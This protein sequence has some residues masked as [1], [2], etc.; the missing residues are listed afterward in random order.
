MSTDLEQDSLKY[1]KDFPPG[2]IKIA[3]SKPCKTQRDLSLSYTPGVAFPCLEIAKDKEKVFDYTNRGNSVAI[4]T[5]GTAVLGL[6]NI[7]PE[8]GLPVMEGKAVLFKKFA[9]ID[10]YPLCVNFDHIQGDAQK[11]EAFVNMVKSIEPSFAG[12]NL[13]DIAAPLCF[14]LQE[15]LDRIMDIPVFHDDQFGTAIIVIGGLI[16]ALKTVGKEFSEIKIVINGAGAAGIS[17]AKLL[18]SFGAKKEH[19]FICDSKGLLVSSRED[20]NLQKRAF[21]LGE[22]HGISKSGAIPQL[23]EVLDGADVFIGVSVAGALKPES[24]KKM[25]KDPIIFA[26]ANPVPE[27][28]PEEAIGAG[29]RIIATGRSDFPN[30]VNNALGY[31]GIFRGALDTRSSTINE[32]M[33][34]A[35]AKAIASLTNEPVSGRAKEILEEAYAEEAAGGLFSLINPLSEN[36]IIPKQFD[37]RVVPRVA[38]AVAQAAMES[39]VARVKISDLDWYEKNVM[40][41]V[42]EGCR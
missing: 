17:C 39:G 21:A 4:V 37:I 7:G 40:E 22:A 28:M 27:I 41:R 15:K 24:V 13:E 12:I 20:L 30:Q 16:N 5:D 6:G 8:A 38:R 11:I 29:A 3:S 33:K 32:S 19:I 31:P 35:A 10:A 34:L 25:N 42:E 26:V 18:N 23:S 1:H 9:D 2:K 36:Y 14:E